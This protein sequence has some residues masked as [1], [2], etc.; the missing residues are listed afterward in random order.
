MKY[1]FIRGTVL[2][3][4]ENMEPV[5]GKIILVEDGR[6]SGIADEDTCLQYGGFC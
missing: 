2:D 6:I 4:S 3:G 5:Q 1:A